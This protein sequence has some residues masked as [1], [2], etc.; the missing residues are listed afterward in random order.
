[1][2]GFSGIRIKDQENKIKDETTSRKW[3]K[4]IMYIDDG[5]SGKSTNRP[6]LQQL[7]KDFKTEGF[8]AIIFTKLDRLARNL[9]DTLNFY[10]EAEKFGVKMICLDSP[11][12]ST[13]GPMGSVM[14]QIMGAFAQFER[15]LIRSRTTAGRMHK[16]KK[17]EALMGHP[18]FGYYLD[19]TTFTIKINKQK[20]EIIHKI[21]NLYLNNRLS[22]LDV[23]G[24]LTDDGVP[25]PSALLGRKDASSHWNVN[26]VREIL[27][28]EAYTGIL[29]H[30]NQYKFK[31]NDKNRVL[32][33]KEKK[34]KKDWVPVQFPKIIE[35]EQFDLVQAKIQHNKVIPKK[36]HSG[37]ENKFMAENVLKCRHC[38]AKLYKQTTGARN[39]IYYACPWRR[40]SAK[41]LKARNKEKCHLPFLNSDK[42]DFAVFNQVVNLI[43]KPKEYVEE[44]VKSKPTEELKTKILSLTN[45]K[46]SLQEKLSRAVKIE[47]NAHNPELLTLYSQER[48]KIEKEYNSV[49]RTLNTAQNELSFHNHKLK[50]LEE[51]QNIF[52]HPK[53]EHTMRMK[54]ALKTALH[55]LPFEDKKKLV[56]AVI[57]P[58]T[59]GQVYI[60]ELDE[61]DIGVSKKD[62]SNKSSKPVHGNKVGE[63]EIMV[64][65]DFTL[66]PHRIIDIISSHNDIV[67]KLDK[68]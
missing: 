23:A 39:F 59:G 61:Y 62:G 43:I 20:S 31:S 9:R 6:A 50:K 48:E 54:I 44:W 4:P 38:G 33:T 18:P 1:M 17:G 7:V 65:L 46:T 49:S 28:N 8:H 36:K 10:H 29:I 40:A 63:R 16:W 26:T 67:F 14:L 5:I 51:F 66:Q 22:I 60:R 53:R 32:K 15:D 2:A 56:E 12:I 25:T 19:K 45:K 35:K 58:E 30:Y 52:N 21:Y 57:S 47:I 3:D 42:V 55:K 37:L 68:R 11:I 41:Q 64:E 13:D 34:D 24:K 27:R